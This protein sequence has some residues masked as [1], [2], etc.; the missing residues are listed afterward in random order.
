MRG[1]FMPRRLITSEICRNEKFG[2]LSDAARVLFIGCFANADDDGRLK[3][4]PKYLKALIF[5]YDN[6]TPE[7]VK[8]LR[9]HCE[10]QGLVYIYN[11][12][13]SEYI[14]CIGWFQH[15]V[16]RK[17]R[18]RPSILPAPD[19]T[20]ATTG[21]PDGNQEATEG[22]P[23]VHPNPIQSNIIQYNIIYIV[24]NEQKLIIHQK[25]TD[26][27]SRAIKVAL[28]DY[29]EAQI[30]QAVKNYA[31]IVKGEEYYFN[32]KWI[33][34]DFL[35]RGLEKFL[36]LEIAKSNY[37]DTKNGKNRGSNQATR[38]AKRNTKQDSSKYTCGKYGDFVKH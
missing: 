33:L 11:R 22:Q 9:D 30:I 20:M 13:G 29:S 24:W 14:Y 12:N 21:L 15:Q 38:D 18:Y 37:K 31:E 28:K 23:P 1:C 5:P 27:I 3:A 8:E 2:S 10:K 4:S 17:D 25:Q 26:S 36:D 16:I 6:K 32:H 34:K 7:S 35:K 19:G